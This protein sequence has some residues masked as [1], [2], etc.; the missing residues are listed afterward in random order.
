M[1]KV[2]T[3]FGVMENH[4]THADAIGIDNKDKALEQLIDLQA[5]ANIMTLRDAASTADD[6]DA[7]NNL[8]LAVN[9]DLPIII[10]QLLGGS[11]DGSKPK[12]YGAHTEFQKEYAEYDGGEKSLI[13]YMNKYN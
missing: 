2:M 6:C 9:H 12:S 8:V 7:A 4:S 3:P 11:D 5:F 13:D 1:K 10:R